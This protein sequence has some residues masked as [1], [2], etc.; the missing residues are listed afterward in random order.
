MV[1]FTPRPNITELNIV[2]V[3]SGSDPHEL[4]SWV[5]QFGRL[6][7]T[8]TYVFFQ[9]LIITPPNA[10]M[11]SDATVTLARQSVA[12]AAFGGVMIKAFFP[13]PRRRRRP[14]GDRDKDNLTYTPSVGDPA[15]LSYLLVGQSPSETQLVLD[16]SAWGEWNHV[17]LLNNLNERENQCYDQEK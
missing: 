9:A 8:A 7:A 2:T 1:D 3:Y 4:I 15:R 16:T 12:L 14:G 6:T 13:P 5:H 11:D 10:D 17:E